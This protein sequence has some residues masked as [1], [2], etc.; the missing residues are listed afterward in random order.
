MIKD[1][2]IKDFEELKQTNNIYSEFSKLFKEVE[3]D[4]QLNDLKQKQK[5][6]QKKL[7]NMDK[8]EL[9]NFINKTK[10]ELI[11]IDIL[12]NSDSRII[13][14]NDL[15]QRIELENEMIKRELK[16]M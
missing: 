3:N 14:L 16:E 12:I 15:R 10:Q 4:K 11:D 6:L 7:I 13:R 5:E 1:K 8:L 9:D 2:L